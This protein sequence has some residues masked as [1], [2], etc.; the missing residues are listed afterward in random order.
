MKKLIPLYLL[1]F[2]SIVFNVGTIVLA[3]LILGYYAIIYIALVFVSNFVLQYFV[4][5][6]WLSKMESMVQLEFKQKEGTGNFI[7]KTMILQNGYSGFCQLS[8]LFQKGV[9]RN[10]F[11][12][13]KVDDFSLKVFTST[14]KFKETVKKVGKIVDTHFF[15]NIAFKNFYLYI[16]NV[17]CH[18]VLFYCTV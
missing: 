5:T 8:K 15:E 14:K 18:S 11:L 4:G 10:P 1:S 2:S 16:S 3:I 12:S 6:L 13:F 9:G 7:W 17:F